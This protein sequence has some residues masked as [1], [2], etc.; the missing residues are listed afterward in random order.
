MNEPEYAGKIRWEGYND[1]D[2]DSALGWTSGG[3]FPFA[4]ILTEDLV[5]VGETISTISYA[6]VMG[7]AHD[8]EWFI[9]D[10]AGVILDLSLIHI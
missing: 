5:S 10:E 3:L 7:T 8:T 4:I 9:A 2:Y 1:G 6:E